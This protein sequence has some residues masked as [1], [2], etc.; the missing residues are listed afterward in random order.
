MPWQQY[1]QES[2]FLVAVQNIK[3]EHPSQQ[4][5]PTTHGSFPPAVQL[6]MQAM[7]VH[8]AQLEHGKT[9]QNLATVNLAQVAQQISQMEVPKNHLVRFATTVVM[10]MS[11]MMGLVC[12]ML[13]T[14]LVLIPIVL[15]QHQAS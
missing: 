3:W 7:D 8:H 13:Y 1:L 14:S 11:A 2:S 12:V 4:A 10:V 15:F 5:Q 9:I 6:V